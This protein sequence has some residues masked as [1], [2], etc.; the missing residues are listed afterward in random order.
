MGAWS[1]SRA[2]HCRPSAVYGLAP[3]SLEAYAFDSAVVRW[4][5]AFE[6]ALQDAVQGAKTD[7]AAAAA[8][9]RVLRRWL[10]SER[11]YADPSAA[12]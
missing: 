10:P 11:R 1:M 2:M 5:T 6:A 4:G 8:R 7:Q 3:G 12:R 9:Q